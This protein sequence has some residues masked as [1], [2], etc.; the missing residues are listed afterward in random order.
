MMLH[1]KAGNFYT[2]LP[3]VAK[4]HEYIKKHTSLTGNVQVWDPCAGMGNLLLPPKYILPNMILS[5]LEEDDVKHL[6]SLD[7]PSET[8]I[9]KYDFL[10]GIDTELPQEVQQRLREKKTWLFIMNPP[11]ITGNDLAASFGTGSVKTGVSDNFVKEAMKDLKL[12]Q[13][14][15]NT[16][17]QFMFRI[18]QLVQDYELDATV[19]TFSNASFL[20][21]V[22][23]SRFREIWEEV[24]GFQ[25]GFCF[26][27]I[28][29]EGLK[30]KW[31]VLFT[32]WKT[33][34][35]SVPV[36]VDIFETSLTTSGKKFFGPAN[37]P[38]SKWIARPSRSIVRPPM[39]SAMTIHHS[40][41]RSN[42]MADGAIGHLA[43]NANNVRDAHLAAILSGPTN[44]GHGWSITKYNFSQSMVALACAKLV[45]EDWLNNRDEFNVPDNMHEKY[46]E[47]YYDS[48]IY[49]LFHNANQT[50]SLGD[51]S[52]LGKTYDITNEFFW[53]P[54][55]YFASFDLPDEIKKQME[56]PRDT[57]VSKWINCNIKAF[58]VQAKKVID[59][60]NRLVELSASHR[61]DK[62]IDSKYQLDRWDAGWY[63]IRY[64]L[65][66]P[67]SSKFH[68]GLYDFD[69]AFKKLETNLRSTYKL[70]KILP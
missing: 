40:K 29:F 34:A 9:F 16:S 53:I 1:S 10:N 18:L 14:C 19:A 51:I 47:F 48:V 26:P 43:W 22:N 46:E 50:V 60:A 68:S 7:F 63:Q 55:R 64:G 21:G 65:L 3:W 54:G 44:S 15:Q 32:V 35:P 4:A 30:K 69:V 12:H 59:S 2:P 38:L 36:E 5:T 28:E 25:D 39:S 8:P 49:S 24:F 6:W 58:S 42:K 61:L 33:G 41:S 67:N 62:T 70:L 17:A 52:Y 37:N 31:P 11:F 20:T 56:S 13:A 27:S 45:Q 23:Y 66:N 57:F